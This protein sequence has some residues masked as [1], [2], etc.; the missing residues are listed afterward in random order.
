MSSAIASGSEKI[1]GIKYL[2]IRRAREA[3]GRRGISLPIPAR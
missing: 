3:Q 2:L 1:L